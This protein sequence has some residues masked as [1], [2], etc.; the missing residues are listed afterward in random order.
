MTS[1][2]KSWSRRLNTVLMAGCLFAVTA[3]A[4]AA[5]LSSKDTAIIQG[6]VLDAGGAS[7]SGA[8]ISLTPVKI[9]VVSDA[10]GAYRI[11]DVP[12]GKY[13]LTVSY[14]GFAPLSTDVEVTAGQTLHLDLTIKVANASQAI[15]V[16][17][18]RPHGEAEAINQTRSAD[19]LMQVMP[20][21]VIT[22]L[23]NANV[24]DA[25]AFST[26][27]R[28]AAKAIAGSS[29]ADAQAANMQKLQGTCGGCHMAHR[30]GAA[31]NFTIK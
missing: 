12:A 13:T 1:L 19:N 29:D 18:S 7:V 5:T 2:L 8:E 9:T 23:P 4:R 3:T 16:T 20:S 14:V 28:D 17:A 27:G 30:G 6:T 11:T 24:A 21:E 10:Q 15:L 26:T 22:S 31:P 25:I